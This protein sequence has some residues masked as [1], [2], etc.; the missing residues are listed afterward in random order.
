MQYYIKHLIQYKN[1]FKLYFEYFNA[2]KFSILF[3]KYM[4]EKLRLH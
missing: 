1:I 4:D 3:L 2:R